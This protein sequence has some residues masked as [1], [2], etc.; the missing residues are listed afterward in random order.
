[1]EKNP[2]QMSTTQQ[3][4]LERYC[5]AIDDCTSVDMLQET[6]KECLKGFF[7]QRAALQWVL[8]DVMPE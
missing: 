5:R 4:E 2:L 1:M 6:A 8:R 7:W 3:F